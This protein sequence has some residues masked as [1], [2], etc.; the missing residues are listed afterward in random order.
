MIFEIGGRKLNSRL[1]VGTGKLSTYKLIP[2]IVEKSG[3]EVLTVAVRKI[4]PD[5]KIENVLNYIPKNIVIMINTSGAR[6]AEEAVKIAL[7]G[8]EIVNSKWIKVEIEADTRYLA[9]DNEETLKATKILVEKGF[10]VFPYINPDLILAKKLEKV[11]ATAV[12]PLGSF[13]GTNRGI[14]CETLIKPIIQELRVPV[15]IDAGIGKPSDAAKAM[16]LGAEAVLVNTA[17][18][19]AKN[20][21]DMAVALS[22][23]VK[24]G[25]V[26][27][28]MGILEEKE[29]AEATS[30]L[31]GFLSDGRK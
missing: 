7:V 27:Y 4:N 6:N 22:M 1:F 13:I 17:I 23:A 26:A 3:V 31:T 14:K 28:E 15:I 2:E 10:H 5:A 25:R 11:G 21:V 9:P 12:M 30:P 16:E 29:F 8:S 18:A 20:P 24:A 19:V